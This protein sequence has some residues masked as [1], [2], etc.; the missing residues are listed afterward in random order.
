MADALDVE[1]ACGNVGGDDDIELAALELIDSALA[2][3]LLYVA[4]QRCTRVTAGFELFGQLH[5]CG[6]GAHE[7]QHGI[8]S[9][10]FEN[11]S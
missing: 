1:S 11:A 2:L 6:F 4:I 10:G 5:R 7:N 3:F 9:F 8:E